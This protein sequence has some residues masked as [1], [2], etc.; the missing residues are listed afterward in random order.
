[1]SVKDLYPNIKPSL[2][3]DF[4]N[5][6]Q[7]DPRITF[8]RD[9]TAT[10]YDGKTVAKAEEN[11]LKY[12]QEF[13]YTVWTKQAG[14]SV[15]SNT[16]TAPDG[17]TTADTITFSSTASVYQSLVFPIG[18]EHTASIFVK[19]INGETVGFWPDFGSGNPNKRITVTLNGEWQRVSATGVVT[20]ST[21]ITFAIRGLDTGLT[22][23]NIF[24]WGA[25][26]EQRSQV[27]AYTP[28]TSQPI[29]NYIPVLQ[30]AS[31]NQPRFDHDVRPTLTGT[32]TVSGATI[33]LPTVFSDGSAPFTANDFYKNMSITVA[34]SVYT[35]NSYVGSTR[36]ATLS[37]SPTTGSQAFVLQNPEQGS[38]KGLLIEEQRTNLLTHSEDF[39]TAVWGNSNI[40]VTSNAIVAPNGTLTGDMLTTNAVN[41]THLIQRTG[42]MT[43]NG[44][45]QSYFAKAGT[46]RY[47]A[48]GDGG[49]YWS[50]V[51]F[52]L[53]TGQ[54]ISSGGRNNPQPF[55][56]DVGNGWYRIGYIA[57]Q[58]HPT[59]AILDNS[60]N[61]THAVAGL[62]VYL[63]GADCQ[64]AVYFPTSYIKTTSAQ[65]TRAADA[66]SITGTNFSSWYR[67]DEGS[68]YAE[69]DVLTTN[70]GVFPYSIAIDDNSA[71]N[72]FEFYGFATT[73]TLVEVSLG[74]P[75][76]Q[77]AVSSVVVNQPFKVSASY[78]FN[79]IAYS[80]GGRAVLTD[81]TANV[82]YNV[83]QLRT[84]LMNGHI[85]KLAYYSKRLSNSELVALT[86]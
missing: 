41:S 45:M 66:A 40:T 54:I 85:K 25:Q 18:T 5:V 47:I 78:A 53:L 52:D 80:V 14:A 23:T 24:V 31:A 72:R 17:T 70:A 49:F 22:A 10:Y 59:V 71:N 86:S 16:A 19:G 57:N 74:S 15:T 46:A 77:I 76:A 64:N 51:S 21:N 75:G 27:T 33:T 83:T 84:K 32:G 8:T 30:S 39:S 63:W 50:A 11:L 2:N 35:V 48:I 61:L 55:C 1:M 62:S 67:Q 29:T 68:L 28:T 79:D 69:L 58:N 56:I 13:D 43:G 7:L 4:A 12:S 44:A 26:F 3:L 9:S 65:V 42:I 20:G 81:N 73:T 6:K 60:R 37:G 36:V 38:C 34:G 82:P